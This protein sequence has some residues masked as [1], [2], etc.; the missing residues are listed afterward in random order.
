MRRKVFC[1]D[2]SPKRFPLQQV[3]VRR[4]KMAAKQAGSG[5]ALATDSIPRPGDFPLGSPASRAAARLQAGRLSDSRRRM[6]IISKRLRK[7]RS[8]SNVILPHEDPRDPTIP[9]A[10][11][12]NDC[13]DVLMRYVYRPTQW[14]KSPTAPVPICQ[15]CGTPYRR[16]EREFPG[17]ILYEAD[18]MAKHISDWSAG[19]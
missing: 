5:A 15:G 12:W 6:Q 11:E 3:P 13:G 10:R 2:G 14:E 8:P 16:S 7:M 18:C 9:H 19:S 4:T 1:L 17:V